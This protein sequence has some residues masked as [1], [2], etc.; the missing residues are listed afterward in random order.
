MNL[1]ARTGSPPYFPQVALPNARIASSVFAPSCFKQPSRLVQVAAARFDVRLGH[2]A[3]PARA[4]ASPRV[5]SHGRAARSAPSTA[6]VA[7]ARF[8]A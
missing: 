7:G 3:L 4:P 5:R 2:S 8:S 6:R 1:N